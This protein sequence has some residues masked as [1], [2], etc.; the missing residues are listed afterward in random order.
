MPRAIKPQQ[1]Q[2]V[3]ASESPSAIMKK[4][5]INDNPKKVQPIAS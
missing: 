2:P 4:E 1:Q 5:Q 3:A